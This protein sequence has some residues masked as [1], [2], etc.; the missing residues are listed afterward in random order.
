M[1]VVL[2]KAAHAEHSMQ[3][4]GQLVA[5]YQTQFAI[6]QRQIA[7]GMRVE[8]IGQD[9]A[10][11]VHGLD[12]EILTVD[13]GGIHVL[14]IVIP[15]T[16]GL[17]QRAAHDL[18]RGDFDIAPLAMDIAPEI[19]QGVFQDHAL[20]QIEREARRFV[21]E[22]EQI[23]LAAQLAMIALFRLLNTRDDRRRAL[24]WT[25]NAVP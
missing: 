24:P 25:V 23:Q 17:P 22:R 18:R 9:A 11:T 20:R 12:G 1:R 7:I 10:W 3:R 19:D 16:G 8:L 21:A 14:F 2:R 13:N 5:V 4:A 6:A 15:V